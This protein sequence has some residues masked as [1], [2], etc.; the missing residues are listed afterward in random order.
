MSVSTPTKLSGWTRWVLKSLKSNMWWFHLSIF[1]LHTCICIIWHEHLCWQCHDSILILLLYELTLLTHK[2]ELC[3]SWS[4]VRIQPTTSSNSILLATTVFFL[5][6]HVTINFQWKITCFLLAT[7]SFHFY[8][9]EIDFN[10]FA[11]ILIEQYLIPHFLTCLLSTVTRKSIS[12]FLLLLLLVPLYKFN[13]C[14]LWSDI[15]S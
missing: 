2:S 12:K 10:L 15:L 9:A 1:Q 4:E 7:T 5:F 8:C 3:A 11:F 14:T 13:G 6:L